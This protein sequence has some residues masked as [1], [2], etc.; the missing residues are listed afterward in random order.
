M[1]AEQRKVEP[2]AG[3]EIVPKSH[4]GLPP[5]HIT[6]QAQTIYLPP[7]LREHL[8]WP[9][10]VLILRKALPGKMVYCICPGESEQHER[11]K[12]RDGTI[13]I[14]L[15]STWPTDNR[16]IHKRIT[17]DDTPAIYFTITE[18]EAK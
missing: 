15:Y 18:G 7:S 11:R 10:Y 4:N 5:D 3:F 8:G 6:I 13:S 16:Y 14:R 17:T 2:P 12:M 9:N 1:S